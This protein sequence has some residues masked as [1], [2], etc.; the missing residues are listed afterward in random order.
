[1]RQQVI[2][3]LS[4][5]QGSARE[6]VRVPLGELVACSFCGECPP[7]SGQLVSGGRGAYICEHC[8]RRWYDALSDDVAVG[9]EDLGA[10]VMTGRVPHDT[11]TARAEIALAFGHALFLS[12]DRRTVP[13]VEGGEL[14][15]PCLKEAQV[16][17]AALRRQENVITIEDV[18]FVDEERASI[19]FAIAF[20]GISTE[21]RRGR[22]LLVDSRWLMAR[23]T[24]CE[25]MSLIGVQCPPSTR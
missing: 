7:E 8:I 9:D 6:A 19:S 15:G 21:Q 5:H 24:F 13:T 4:G 22:A 2:Q 10:T 23:Q 3:S 11:E 14:L 18:E 1:V 25:L 16:R 17:H 20:E 12:E